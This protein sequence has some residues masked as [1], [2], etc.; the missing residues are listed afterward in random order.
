MESLQP[1]LGQNWA[2]ASSPPKNEERE[3]EYY[4][5][6]SGFYACQSLDSQKKSN[7]QK[8]R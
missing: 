6:G 5:D 8:L 4:T 2:P 1:A 3:C 7:L